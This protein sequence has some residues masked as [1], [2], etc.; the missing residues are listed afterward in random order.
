MNGVKDLLCNSVVAVMLVVAANGGFVTDSKND[1]LLV[2][3]RESVAV[4]V[5]ATDSIVEPIP[6]SRPFALLNERV[7]GGSGSIL[8]VM[9]P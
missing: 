5:C 7:C 6:V 1:L 3:P 2:C 9:V 8:N 4:T